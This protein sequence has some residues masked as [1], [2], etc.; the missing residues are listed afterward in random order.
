M[1]PPPDVRS[2]VAKSRNRSIFPPGLEL[3]TTM[4]PRKLLHKV[5]FFPQVREG[6][7]HPPC[8][9]DAVREPTRWVGSIPT[10][11]A[12][13][14]PDDLYRHMIPRYYLSGFWGEASN[15]LLKRHL[16]FAHRLCP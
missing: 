1:R 7:K 8:S 4:L 12:V 3:N 2:R 11:T 6:A 13:N 16:M 5:W 10:A 15:S 14:R 9:G